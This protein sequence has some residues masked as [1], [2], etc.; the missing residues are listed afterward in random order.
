MSLENAEIFKTSSFHRESLVNSTC[1][2]EEL[3]LGERSNATE[4]VVSADGGANVCLVT[5]EDSL[6]DVSPCDGEVSGT[7]ATQDKVTV[8]GDLIVLFTIGSRSHKVAITRFYTI[9]TNHNHNFGLTP[10]R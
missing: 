3:S 7:G 2:I 6:R 10:L 9:P 1:S 5:T 4:L 8:C